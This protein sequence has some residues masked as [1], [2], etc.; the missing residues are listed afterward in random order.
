M[1]NQSV[2]PRGAHLVGSV[3]LASPPQLFRVAGDLL[4]ARLKRVPD[5]EPE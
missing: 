5:G 2:Q 1:G 4:G 3:A